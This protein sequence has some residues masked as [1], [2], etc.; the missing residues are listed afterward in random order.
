MAGPSAFD[1]CKPAVEVLSSL[2]TNIIGK[3]GAMMGGSE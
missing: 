1:K 3:M 2:L